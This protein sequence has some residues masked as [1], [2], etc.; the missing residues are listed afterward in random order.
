MGVKSAVDYSPEHVARGLRDL[1]AFWTSYKPTVE[2]WQRAGGYEAHIAL[3]AA[4]K[5]AKPHL[6]QDLRD[7]LPDGYQLKLEWR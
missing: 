4:A 6:D 2:I 3:D 5:V 7:L 1:I